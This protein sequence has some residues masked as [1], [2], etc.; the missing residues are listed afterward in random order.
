MYNLFSS[1]FHSLTRSIVSHFHLVCSRLYYCISFM[2][3][4]DIKKTGCLSDTHITHHD[5]IFKRQMLRR[6]NEQKKKST[7]IRILLDANAI[8]GAIASD[9]NLPYIIWNAHLCDINA[10]QTSATDRD[11]D[12]ARWILSW[13]RRR[14]RNK[15]HI[16]RYTV[17]QM[18][19]KSRCRLWPS[20][21]SAGSL[22]K[23]TNV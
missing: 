9:G 8:H 5:T 6:K 13:T 12:R 16:K 23:R 1:L 14:R 11:R 21:S 15:N 19:N 10:V 7:R 18:V 4:G 22:V 17:E 2:S 20:P 3:I